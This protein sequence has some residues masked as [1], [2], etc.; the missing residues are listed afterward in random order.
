MR[1]ERKKA[2]FNIM[3]AK[4]N[5]AHYA[6]SDLQKFDI[7]REIITQNTDGL[8]QK[9]NSARVIELHGNSSQCVCVDCGRKYSAREAEEAFERTLI[10]PKCSECES[11]L[12]PDVVLFGEKLDPV[13][14][15]LA[16]QAVT[17]CKSILVVGTTASVYP[18]VDLPKDGEADGRAPH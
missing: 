3:N 12:K 8:H 11:V 17:N 7:V 2:G 9:A 6:L 13:K 18:S 10:A 16:T 15:E 1:L 14:I 5:P 4:P